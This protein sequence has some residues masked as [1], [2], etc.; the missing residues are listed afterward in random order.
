M[1]SLER[2][3]LEPK[4]HYRKCIEGI[5]PP[6]LEQLTQAVKV[7]QSALQ[8]ISKH[9]KRMKRDRVREM[10]LLRPNNDLVDQMR[11]NMG[12]H[13]RCEIVLISRSGLVLKHHGWKWTRQ[14]KYPPCMW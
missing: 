6:D 4:L 13:S 3:G 2:T 12:E 8:Q 9:S 5:F 10:H 7:S 1:N 11:K 14:S